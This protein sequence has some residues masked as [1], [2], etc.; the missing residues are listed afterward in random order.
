MAAKGMAR[1]APASPS[2]EVKAARQ[3]IARGFT[4]TD[5]SHHAAPGGSSPGPESVTMRRLPT[6]PGQDPY[7]RRPAV[8]DG[9]RIG[10]T[11][12][13]ACQIRQGPPISKHRA[14]R[15]AGQGDQGHT[16]DDE[17]QDP[18]AKDEPAYFLFD[19]CDEFHELARGGLSES[20]T[21]GC[22]SNAHSRVSRKNR[23]RRLPSKPVR[24]GQKYRGKA[25]SVS[26]VPPPGF[27]IPTSLQRREW[28]TAAR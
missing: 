10:P 3:V 22:G 28:S 12:G 26:P 15:S 19:F 25:A 21:A 1:S 17:A 20:T 14:S 5:C 13:T 23:G 27:R 6:V 24:C 7:E 11:M 8:R 18:L 4:P 2:R 16:T 9:P